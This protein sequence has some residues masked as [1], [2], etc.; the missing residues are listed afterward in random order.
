MLIRSVI[1]VIPFGLGLL[2]V[3][4]VVLASIYTAYRDIFFSG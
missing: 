2:V 1:A 3:V 4:P